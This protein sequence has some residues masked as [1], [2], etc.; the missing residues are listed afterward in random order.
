MILRSIKLSF[1]NKNKIIFILFQTL[2]TISK[3]V[4]RFVQ[5]C[6]EAPLPC[7]PFNTSNAVNTVTTKCCSTDLCNNG[8]DGAITNSSPNDNN[9]DN[10]NDSANDS[11]S[12]AV[13]FSVIALMS[14]FVLDN[15]LAW[16]ENVLSEQ[17]LLFDVLFI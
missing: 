13:T 10:N 12:I 2:T 15:N 5:N 6:V 16:S 1:N 11:R 7:I 3:D 4:R 8:K 9:N 14:A 17:K